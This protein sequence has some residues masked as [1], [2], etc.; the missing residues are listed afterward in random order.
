MNQAKNKKKSK[1][2]KSKKKSKNKKK[3]KK[4]AVSESN[5]PFSNNVQF[6]YDND[7]EE[8]NVSLFSYENKTDLENNKKGGVK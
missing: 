2:S 1:K 6:F 3:S 7:S 8:K 5:I 4:R